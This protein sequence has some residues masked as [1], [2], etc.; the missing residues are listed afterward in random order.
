MSTVGGCNTRKYHG[1]LIAPQPQIDDND[2]VLVSCI[3]EEVSYLDKSYALATHK[4]PDAYYPEGFRNAVEFDGGVTLRWVYELGECI[5]TK[6]VAMPEGG[7]VVLIRYS[8]ANAPG[9]VSLKISP[10]LAFRCNHHLRKA[11]FVAER[12]VRPEDGGYVMQPYAD[13]VPLY[14]GASKEMDFVPGP[15]WYYNVEYV[16]EQLR[17]YSYRE[18]L[19]IP[20]YFSLDLRKRE[21]FVLYIGLEE[22]KPGALAGR[23]SAVCRKKKPIGDRK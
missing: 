12:K 8:F 1:L 23:F 2:H 20:G 18:D 19:F 6:E 16:Q 4:Y 3:D 21:N 7:A 22:C 10:V 11:N 5:F 14:I 15:D 9:T 17:G 13:Y